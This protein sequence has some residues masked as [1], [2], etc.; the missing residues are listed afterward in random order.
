LQKEIDL[1]NNSNENYSSMFSFYYTNSLGEIKNQYLP[2]SKEWEWKC[3]FFP[4]VMRHGVYPFFTSDGTRISV[5]GN[6]KGF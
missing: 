4:A 3:A 6:I 1:F 5:S 2:I